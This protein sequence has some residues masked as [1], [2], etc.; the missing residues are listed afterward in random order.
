MTRSAPRA[1]SVP[2]AF[3]VMSFSTAAHAQTTVLAGDHSVDGALCVGFHCTSSETFPG[4]ADL[5]IK[6]SDPRL[7]FEDTST[8]TGVATT[9]WELRANDPGTGPE[10]FAIRNADA[11]RTI[12]RLDRDAPANSLYVASDGRVGF[13]TT[14]PG[15]KVSVE[16]NDGYALRLNRSNTDVSSTF[17]NLLIYQDGTLAI[18]QRVDGVANFMIH[19][20]AMTGGVDISQLGVTV[21]AYSTAADFTVKSFSDP[22]A[23]YVNGQFGYVGLG[24]FFPDSQL[25]VQR[26]DGNARIKVEN[27][28]ASPTGVR[29]MFNM[30]NKG[31]SYFT[32]ANTQSG[33]TWY[34]THEQA[35]PNRFIITDGVADGP[36][37][38]LTA[39][40][41]LT[42]QGQLFTAGSCAAGCDRV[43]DADYPLPTIAE[44]A[45]QIRALKHLP[46]VGP[47][48]EDGPFN[49]T[50]MTGGMLNE[51]EKAHLYIAELEERDTARA[52][53]VASL[54]R[55]N[56]AMEARLARLEAALEALLPEK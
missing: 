52:Q 44:Q 17:Y 32:L 51:L 37:M 53:D 38:T 41:N 2:M 10:Y 16:A 23:L 28:T 47:T 9:D 46:S 24:T 43:F 50:A 45:A 31:G 8:I 33:T 3:L 15:G 36:E 25:H 7:L 22:Y 34:F 30:T 27:T 20:D 49:L 19:K 55:Q 54:R 6:E 29:E 48:P 14:L 39:E 12:L 21:N 35:A 40:G 5:K 56:A 4:D 11:D 1:F 13:G 26:T 18:S 42:I